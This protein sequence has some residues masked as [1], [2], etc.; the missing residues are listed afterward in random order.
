MKKIIAFL[1]PLVWVSLHS[2]Q[3]TGTKVEKWGLY[4]VSLQ[5]PDTGNPFKEVQLS[6]TF[7]MGS[8][9][10]EVTGFY[11]GQGTYKI[12]F[13]PDKTGQWT[14]ETRSNVPALDKQT[15]HFTCVEATGNNHG[16]VKVRNTYHFEYADGTPYYQVGT[17]CYAWAHQGDSLEKATLETLK[18]APFNKIRM[19]IFPKDY[20]YNENEPE[21]YPF[22]RDS[23]GFHNFSRFSPK[24]WQH[25]EK[26]ILQL[27]ELGIEADII[28]FHPYDRWGYANMPDYQDNFYLKYAL[29][30]LSA[31]RHVWW[32]MANEF[33][34]MKN[35]SMDDWHRFFQIV[36]K[37]DPY[38][39]LRSIHNG[40]V[41]YDHSLPWVTHASIQSTHFDSAGVWRER[42]KKPLVYD[43]ARYEGDVVQGWGNLSPEEM[44]AMF[45]RSLIT[46][47]YAGHGE[48]YEHP[49]N[50]L[51]WAKGGVL[52]G[53]SPERI[54]FFKKYLK[55]AP[56][57]GFE[58]INKYSAGKYGEQYLYYFDE[59]TPTSW[60]FNLPGKRK[61]KVEIIDTWN[62]ARD[63]LDNLQEPSFTLELPGKPYMAVKIT[64]E[65]FLF[66][67][68]KVECLAGGLNYN[69]NTNHVYFHGETEARLVHTIADEI[70]YTLDGSPAGKESIMYNKPVLIT[71]DLVL[72]SIAFDGDRT[73]DEMAYH[74]IELGLTPAKKIK[75]LEPGLK[76][77]Y[78]EGEWTSMPDFSRMIP[79]R[80]G[81]VDRVHL[82]MEHREDYFGLV[83][84]GYIKVPHDG[85]YTFYVVSDDGAFILVNGQKIVDNDGQ[86]GMEEARGQVGLKAGIHAFRLP[87][88]DNWYDHGL[89]VYYYH[90][91][92]GRKPISKD[93]LFH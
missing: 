80:E 89:E 30:R 87:Y 54:A 72:R 74:F 31:F 78:Y 51:W 43:E 18:N 11:D 65:K 66:P 22:E 85:V 9:K 44:T 92:T 29:A 52:H 73:G 40:Y 77:A 91:K 76:Y 8:E 67:V 58:P 60:S 61:Y 13:M 55:D 21:Y 62:M 25:L 26:R 47:T 23:L 82:N 90:E 10:V 32:S 7:S 81:T 36:Y 6:A 75:N 41:M 64:A 34:F 17:T 83:F 88:F 68:G 59:E 19:C 15:G 57:E 27:Q 84:D 39:H 3:D 20:V 93:M 24:F 35:K 4:E 16:P 14:Y 28:L 53:K 50:I 46:G 1:L 12:R 71:E 33:D 70:R 49:E 79:S 5:G 63:T 56:E 2:C 48:T 45:W 86:H 37:N 69:E 38:N 42:F